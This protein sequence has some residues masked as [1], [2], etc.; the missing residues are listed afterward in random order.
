MIQAIAK[1]ILQT[2]YGPNGPTMIQLIVLGQ[3]FSVV[4]KIA[5]FG[6][7]FVLGFILSR[8]NWTKVQII[9]AQF[10]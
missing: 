3:I 4:R 5:I 1:F 7:I 8:L 10:Q 6:S 9:L 2:I